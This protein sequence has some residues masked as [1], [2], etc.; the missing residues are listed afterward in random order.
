MIS[1]SLAALF[2]IVVPSA[3]QLVSITF[4]VAPTLGKSKSIFFPI[5]LSQK[6]SIFP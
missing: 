6:H 2:I 5:I 1:G 3:K 4:S